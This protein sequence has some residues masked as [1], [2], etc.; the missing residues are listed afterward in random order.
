MAGH[1]R[2]LSHC[3]DRC[4][5]LHVSWA[6]RS[7][8]NCLKVASL[9]A[10]LT[11]LLHPQAFSIVKKSKFVGQVRRFD[12]SF[13]FK[14]RTSQLAAIP[15]LSIYVAISASLDLMLTKGHSF[16]TFLYWAPLSCNISNLKNPNLTKRPEQFGLG[17]ASWS[18]LLVA[19]CMKAF[20]M[21]NY[22]ELAA[23]RL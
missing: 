20:H 16:L 10:P 8:H 18:S 23:F 6:C 3:F 7:L 4:T 12:S 17:K 1:S 15:V 9:V 2:L 22:C 19:S 11:Y 5:T 21:W 14:A 13:S